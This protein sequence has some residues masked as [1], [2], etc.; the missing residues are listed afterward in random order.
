M[1]QA[2]VTG[3]TGS[4]ATVTLTAAAPSGGATITLASSKYGGG[5]R[6]CQRDG[7]GRCDQRDGGSDDVSRIDPDGGVSFRH[8]QQRDADRQLDDKP[9][10]S[11]RGVDG[12]RLG[13]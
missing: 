1:N 9:F 7:C 8:L 11:D 5:A 3:G 13:P 12:D 2:A 10:W 4:T 6:S